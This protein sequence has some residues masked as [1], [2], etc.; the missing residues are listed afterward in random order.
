MIS[1]CEIRW[2]CGGYGCRQTN[3]YNLVIF[4]PFYPLTGG[5][6]MTFKKFK[7]N[8]EIIFFYTGVPNI[9]IIGCSVGQLL[10]RSTNSHNFGHFFTP[11]TKFSKKK[12]KSLKAILIHGRVPNI[13]I[14]GYLV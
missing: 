7:K 10:P 8:L 5:K 4:W 3:F 2:W 13:I 11:M 9:M 6:K 14:T 1:G 12:M